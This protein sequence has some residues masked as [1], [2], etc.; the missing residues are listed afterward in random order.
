MNSNGKLLTLEVNDPYNPL[1]LPP[2]TFRVRTNDGLAPNGKVNNYAE[3]D[4]ATLV[5]GTTD[6]YDVYKSGTDFAR[7]LRD[8][9]NLIEVLGANTNGVTS[10]DSMFLNCSA[11]SSIPLFDTSNVI[12]F[13]M[14][15]NGCKSL[16][17]VPSYDT[18]NVTSMRYT[19]YD[20]SSLSSIPWFDTSKVTYIEGMLENC[21]SVSSVPLYDTSNV[22]YINNMLANCTSLT[23]IPLFDTSNVVHMDYMLSECTSLTSLPLF[24][25]S[26]V[27]YMGFAFNSCYNVQSGALD[28]YRQASTQTN[29]PIYHNYT[30][31]DC[32][33]NT[34][35]G[36]AELAQIPKD[37]K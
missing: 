6:I 11:L 26:N 28:L 15:F 32:G 18:S 21:S 17:S 4:T 1:G 9:T 16:T 13:E 14:T 35:T 5:E 30:F 34:Q 3:Y 24:D 8:S 37:W 12:S 10:I 2:N 7:L 29:P 19:F 20:C 33:I 31:T 27:K 23:S 22:V 36:S 25:T